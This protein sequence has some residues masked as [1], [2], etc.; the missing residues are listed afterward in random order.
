MLSDDGFR[1]RAES[2]AIGDKEYVVR[3]CGLDVVPGDEGDLSRWRDE[4]T[5]VMT[6]E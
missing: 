6:E 3:F 1:S 5:F 2:R 4:N